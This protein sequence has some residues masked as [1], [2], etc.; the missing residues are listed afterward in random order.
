MWQV[1]LKVDTG[2]AGLM[3]GLQ[4]DELG[5]HHSIVQCNRHCNTLLSDFPA[6][7]GLKARGTAWYFGASGLRYF[8]LGLIFEAPESLGSYWPAS[9]SFRLPSHSLY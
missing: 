7:L 6:W 5:T 9:P 2:A 4:V 1:G 3:T 8:K